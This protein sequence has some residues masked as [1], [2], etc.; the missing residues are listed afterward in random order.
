MAA[1]DGQGNMRKRL[2]T[3]MDAASRTAIRSALFALVLAS[4]SAGAR[5]QGPC[6][7]VSGAETAVRSS[8]LNVD[9]DA[10]RALYDLDDGSCVWDDASAAALVKRIE[11]AEEHGLDP[12]LFHGEEISA[13]GGPAD[14]RDILLT[15]AALKYAGALTRGLS[16]PETPMNERAA[17]SHPQGESIHAL[18]R[19]LSQG[20]VAEWLDILQPKTPAYVRLKAALSTYR[21]IAEAGGW[22]SLPL[23]LRVKP[24]KKSRQVVALKRR[25]AIEGDLTFDDGAAVYDAA[26]RG[27]V[28]RF[29]ERNGLR[30]DGKLNEATIT[31]L[32]ISAA[33]RVAQ[34]ALNME[35]WRMQTRELPPTRVDVNVPDATAV[36]YRENVP[37]L[38]MNAVVGAPG[39]DTPELM[40]MID[41]IVINPPWNIPRSIIE[42]EIKPLLK[43]KP[44]YLTENRMYWSGDQ[45]IQEP[46]PHNALGRIK[47]EFPNRYSVYLHDTPA[48]KLFTDPE[49]AQSHG[50]VRL[51]RPLDLA[52]ALLQGDPDW[53][54]EDIQDAIRKGDTLRVR[55]PQPVA[56]A[57]GYRTVFVSD[58]GLAQF[59]PDIYGLDTQL[60]LA[61]SQ[62]VTALR[63]EP[64]QW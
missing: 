60:T 26:A 20:R 49:R 47:F 29:Q 54:R 53:S 33:E 27:A 7:D 43:R 6:G 13:A 19:A 37:V 17:G 32:N 63:S 48:R 45:L 10:V 55:V 18:A 57:I 44:N 36:L 28:I 23:S 14:I 34:I 38:K 41:T 24:K 40:S 15:D 25:L 1:P 4:G 35:R 58:D 31:R 21:A 8:G 50:C 22:S 61:L 42:G 56:V 5:A 2:K 30:A 3:F 64:A 39:H 11:A 52:E 9:L 51:E 12:A 59:R 62:K 16:A 46:G